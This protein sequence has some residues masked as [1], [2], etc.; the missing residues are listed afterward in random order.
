MN[1]E[2]KNPVQQYLEKW[3]N[4]NLTK[5]EMNLPQ[6]KRSQGEVAEKSQK[7]GFQTSRRE[8][9]SPDRKLSIQTP[10]SKRKQ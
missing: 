2:T 1:F 8:A 4:V 7:L 9:F 6:I 5:K 3:A 10:S